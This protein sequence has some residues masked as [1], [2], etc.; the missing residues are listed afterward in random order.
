MSGKT[1]QI[2]REYPVNWFILN[3]VIGLTK[4]FKILT[5]ALNRTKAK[6]ASDIRFVVVQFQ[7]MHYSPI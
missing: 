7:T 5:I 4:A 1:V 3:K 6:L 2:D